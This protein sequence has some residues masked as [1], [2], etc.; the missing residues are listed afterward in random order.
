MPQLDDPIEEVAAR[1]SMLEFLLE[2][3]I[4]NQLAVS[5]PQRSDAVKRDLVDRMKKPRADSAAAIQDH[6]RAQVL[7]A[8]S[9]E[10]ME[11]FV[12]K[13]GERE[14]EIRRGL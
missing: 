5:D 7:V 12:Q 11:R 8:R 1:L 2:V 13:L 14:S 10:M 4:A 9:V 3:S 6:P